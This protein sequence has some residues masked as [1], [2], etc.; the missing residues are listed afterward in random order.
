MPEPLAAVGV[1]SSS[2]QRDEGYYTSEIQRRLTA[3]RY[4]L[5][6]HD[7]GEFR[8]WIIYVKNIVNQLDIDFDL[9][10]DKKSV[11]LF[12][13]IAAKSKGSSN[14]SFLSSLSDAQ[15][16]TVIH[17][18][19]IYF[20][21]FNLVEVKLFLEVEPHHIEGCAASLYYCLESRFNPTS[22]TSPFKAQKELHGLVMSKDD[23]VLTFFNK[24]FKLKQD[25]ERHAVNIDDYYKMVFYSGVPSHIQESIAEKLY[26]QPDL[27]LKALIAI[28]AAAEDMKKITA[29]PS[30]S[31]VA[32]A[33]NDLRIWCHI[34]ENAL[35]STKACPLNGKTHNKKA[36]SSS[37]SV[38][39]SSVTAKSKDTVKPRCEHCN[40][41]NHD[42][43]HCF[44]KELD[45]IRSEL[46]A[47][48]AF[49]A[50]G[51]D[52]L[53]KAYA[54]NSHSSLDAASSSFLLDSACTLHVCNDSS[55][56]LNIRNCIPFP[57]E[58]ANGKSVLVR[59]IGD[60]TLSPIS[61]F[62]FR[63]NKHPHPI[64]HLRDVAFSPDFSTKLISVSKLISQVNGISFGKENAVISLDN[65]SEIVVE[66]IGNLYSLP[67][68]L[69][70]AQE[71]A[72]SLF[73]NGRESNNMGKILA[74]HRKMGHISSQS[75][76]D[77]IRS[78]SVKNAT[79]ISITEINNV[80]K[81]ECDACFLGKQSKVKFAPCRSEVSASFVLE[82]LHIDLAGPITFLS[83]GKEDIGLYGYKYYSL[84]IDEYSNYF[85][86]RPLRSKDEAAD[87]V[88]SEIAR[89][90]N[91]T[92]KKVRYLRSDGGG[93][94]QSSSFTSFLRE[95][96]I[97]R[98][99]TT[100]ATP[101]HNGKV[102]RGMRTLADMTRTMMISSN[103]PLFLWP[104]AMNTA[105]F[106]L[107]RCKVN[108]L[109]QT[110][111]QTMVSSIPSL[112]NLKP[113]GCDC[114]YL[115]D[116]YNPKLSPRSIKGAMV[117]Y[118]AENYGI[119][120]IYDIENE[121]LVRSR[122]VTF[123]DNSFSH[124][125][126]LKNVSSPSFLIQPSSSALYY[127]NFLFNLFENDKRIMDQLMVNSS[128]SPSSSSPSSSSSSS[129]SSSL[130]SSSFPSSSLSSFSN[131]SSSSFSSIAS[132]S[133]DI[134]DNS[135]N[136]SVLSPPDEIEPVTPVE[137][138]ISEENIAQ[139]P[140]S[141]D[142]SRTFPAISLLS[143]M[144]SSKSSLPSSHS[145]D[146]AIV[147]PSIQNI[148]TSRANIQSYGE[149]SQSNVD[150]FKGYHIELES[151]RDL[152]IRKYIKPA[153][154]KKRQD[155]LKQNI[156]HIN[157]EKNIPWKKVSTNLST[158]AD[159]CQFTFPGIVLPSL[160]NFSSSRPVNPPARYGSINYEADEILTEGTD[161][162]ED[163]SSSGKER[164]F[165]LKAVEN[166]SDPSSFSEAINGHH[167]NDW[168][169]AMME[170]M[171]ALLE[172]DVFSLVECPLTKKP[173][174][175]KWVYRLKRDENGNPY[176]FKARL[177]IKGFLQM[178]GVDYSDTFAPVMKYPSLRLLLAIA[179][180]CD[181]EIKQM[182]VDNAFLNANLNEDI[183]MVQPQGFISS[184]TP[185][186][187][188]KLKKS[189]YGLKQ[190]PFLWYSDID[191]T[192]QQIGFSRCK[193][194]PCLYVKK[195][196][197]HQVIIIGLFV[198]DSLIIYS[199]KDESEWFSLKDK[200]KEK[201]KIKD[202]G[203]ACF[204]L[205]MKITRKRNKNL[206]FLDQ[207]AYLDN[208]LK[209]FDLF[210][211]KT[212]LTPGTEAKLLKYDNTLEQTSKKDLNLFQQ[213]AGSL[214]YASL[215]TRPDIAFSV[216]AISRYSSK[217]QSSHFIA[218]KKILRYI[219]GTKSQKLVFNGKNTANDQRISLTGYC[220]SDHTGDLEDRKSTSG[221]VLM[222]N[223]CPI[224]WSSKKQKAV[225]KSTCEAEI[226]SCGLAITEMIWF[227]NLLIELSIFKNEKGIIYCDNRA[228]TIIANQ[229]LA[230]TRTKH[231]AVN[232]YF[233]K[234]AI[235]EGKV[236]I[237]WI[238]S[239]DQLADIFTKDL[240]KNLFK[241]FSSM[242]LGEC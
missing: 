79:D 177:V 185:L 218:A 88:M 62:P 178:E 39:S 34:C 157:L 127:Q 133:A 80:I 206:L 168:K 175:C 77:L 166:I 73:R 65:S 95:R 44:K 86:G 49:S 108:N 51:D 7:P 37:S 201:Y 199:K 208:V 171:S 237:K 140:I 189:L 116:E 69:P 204:I 224:H 75:L 191:S 161:I 93:E 119:Y 183:Y 91:I 219:A 30:Y 242:L 163:G 123:K 148:A 173:L 5:A 6:H 131:S 27:S 112:S 76:A 184:E 58:V 194:D 156:L 83:D 158:F 26:S 68:S 151:D 147:F 72:F 136:Y 12:T 98:Q 22:F 121:R 240:G 195:S 103:A 188:Y 135:S 149:S 3:P 43:K 71:K 102:E 126:E 129:S 179:C 122:N 230:N 146:E 200:I 210:D 10:T 38:L 234:E 57:V 52:C 150:L 19:A 35:H 60:I 197:T 113:Y 29:K 160:S 13:E 74:L 89:L 118:D 228:A 130:S 2:I 28:A 23:T 94:Y 14:S 202:L 67:F 165:H 216:S 78:Q 138:N 96:G 196:L 236:D 232:F 222:L 40:S 159:V 125:L 176:R 120:L 117:G 18:K 143:S 55:L 181:F 192:L 193:S 223:N 48:K 198:D 61:S 238:S 63:A 100:R 97:T 50:N 20:A 85:S 180:I 226:M 99:I 42:E 56:F 220:D 229:D 101:Q 213:M 32:L 70:S 81:F 212:A 214:L 46:R 1:S 182:D 107:N 8:Y 104:T 31:Q 203:D 170:E 167:S 187:V 47:Q 45:S 174:P 162:F 169:K 4:L 225:T 110:P 209:K 152:W 137:S 154:D 221:F 87:H 134:S 109:N 211:C 105:V 231:I 139:V 84:I 11:T 155:D 16:K 15:K 241:S 64:L 235:D 233:V 82:R 21:M 54:T 207:N 90:E 92:S 53:H 41:A 36:S 59:Q 172:N 227:R 24:I 142:S 186:S 141:P 215:S 25:I 153:L 205:G 17:S 217:P 145:S 164:V 132:E 9:L 106:L 124:L 33:A 114:F 144:S 111:F 239:Q 190:A 66:R 115:V 128:S